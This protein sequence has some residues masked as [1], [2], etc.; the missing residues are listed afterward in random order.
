MI[1]LWVPKYNVVF[2]DP[3]CYP[4]GFMYISSVLKQAGHQ[5]VVYN[6]NLRDY[7]ENVLFDADVVCFT[8]FEE[9]MDENIR[10]SSRLRDR[11]I[12]TILGGAFASF[13]PAA[14]SNHF[15][16]V[17]VGEGEDA[18]LTALTTDGIIS[19]PPPKLD[20]LPWPDYDGFGI[21]EYHRRRDI[22]YMGVLTSRGCPHNCTFCSATC[23]FQTRTLNLVEDEIRFYVHRY[24]IT[25]LVVNDNTLNTSKQRF[26]RFCDMVA[27]FGLKWSAALR[28]DNLDDEMM[29]RAKSAGLCYSVVGVESFDQK[30][31][32]AMNKKITVEQIEKGLNLL[33]KYAINYTGNIIVE[34]V[35]EVE[36][37]RAVIE[38]YRLY[39]TGMMK[40]IG[41]KVQSSPPE[42]HDFCRAYS[43]SKGRY[44][45]A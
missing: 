30:K 15:D 38:K 41:N 29:A 28:L 35:E 13:L 25:V 39:P 3:C 14:S 20:T 11:G 36:R 5:V 10:L 23:K 32:D 31:L 18:V 9:F 33:Q 8:G 1:A 42:V 40:V 45:A 7:D 4:L 34:S 26:Y 16:C 43:Q 22:R 2:D 6:N 24:G 21:D 27:P 37:H 12:R 17:V 44:Y 19:A